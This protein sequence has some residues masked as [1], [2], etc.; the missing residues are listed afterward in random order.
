MP[1]THARQ[2]WYGRPGVVLAALIIFWPLGLFLTWTQKKYTL[3]DR[4]GLSVALPL[5]TLLIVMAASAGIGNPESFESQLADAFEVVSLTRPTP[6]TPDSDTPATAITSAAIAATATGPG[7][8]N[9]PGASANTAP[10]SAPKTPPK[11]TPG[12]TPGPTPTPAQ[13]DTPRSRFTMN[14]SYTDAGTCEFTLKAGQT[15]GIATYEWWVTAI[16]VT[17]RYT[18]RSVTEAYVGHF[19]QSVLLVTTDTAGK[20]YASVATVSAADAV[21]FAEAK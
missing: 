18:G 7:A 1:E 5:V 2:V 11:A 14:G 20:R 6:E 4:V 10:G 9:R 21:M 12:P 17:T 8:D 19:P 15:S 13:T 16:D 3:S